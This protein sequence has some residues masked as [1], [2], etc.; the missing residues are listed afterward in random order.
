MQVTNWA[1]QSSTSNVAV[2]NKFE[3]L[4]AEPLAERNHLLLAARWC[5]ILFIRSKE[6]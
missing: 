3:Y 1:S 5:S 4:F 6:R 2:R